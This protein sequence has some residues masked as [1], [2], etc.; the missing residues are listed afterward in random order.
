MDFG[1]ED[2]SYGE[3]WSV[4]TENAVEQLFVRRRS[5]P[6][7]I[8]CANDAMAITAVSVLKRHGIK[9]PEN[10]IVTGFDGI[11]EIRYSTPQI[12]TCLCSSE[13]LAQTVTDTIMQILSGRAVPGSVLVVPSF[14]LPKAAAARLP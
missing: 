14:R 8:I 4:P 7:A 3:F 10:V 9:I 5:L 12:T 6:Q 11:N 1:N 2:I 13:H